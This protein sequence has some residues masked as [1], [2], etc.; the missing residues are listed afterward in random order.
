MLHSIWIFIT[1]FCMLH[2]QHNILLK[3]AFITVNEP[4]YTLLKIFKRTHN[5]FP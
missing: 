2:L 5:D 1:H 3:T 4:K